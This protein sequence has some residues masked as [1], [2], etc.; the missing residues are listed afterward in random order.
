MEQNAGLA[1]ETAG[2]AAILEA[3]RVVL[4]GPAR[5]LAA[6]EDV[7]EAY[8]GLGGEAPPVK[9]WRLYRRRRRW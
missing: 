9:G 1:L 3:G 7:R 8:L 4:R 2:E 5:E 6:H